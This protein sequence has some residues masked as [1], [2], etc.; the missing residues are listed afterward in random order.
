MS[1]EYDI[2]L[3]DLREGSFQESFNPE[4]IYLSGM[5]P[6][7]WMIRG[8]KGIEAFYNL[9]NRIHQI[10]KIEDNYTLQNVETALKDL[11]L[12]N[13][14]RKNY[15]QNNIID[16][17]RKALPTDKTETFEIVR[18]VFGITL[19][20][21]YRK[22]EPFIFQKGKNAYRDFFR[23]LS[24]K[25]PNSEKA[26]SEYVVRLHVKSVTKERAIEI[27]D[28]T[29]KTLEYL[30][31]FIL[32][33][34][35]TGSEVRILRQT[36]QN[37]LSY[38][39]KSEA[40]ELT[41]G[42][43]RVKP[44]FIQ[45]DLNSKFFQD[46]SIR[47]LFSLVPFRDLKNPIEKRLHNAITWVGKGLLSDSSIESIISYCSALESLLIRDSRA[48]IVPSVVASLSEYCA[49]LLGKDLTARKKILSTV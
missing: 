45:V 25:D 30:F 2:I 17:A 49:F 28:Q 22:L 46:A 38:L 11:I 10:K 18:N 40:G 33:R 31:A 44:V 8:R 20:K 7:G 4:T 24:F 34:K 21:N 41:T 15:K 39:M 5:Q 14:N 12:R 32:G 26:I 19:S 27:A 37:S 6:T 16:E 48:V 23:D 3:G 29:F 36:D 13:K 1:T 42:S 9:A 47:T 43:I 35:N